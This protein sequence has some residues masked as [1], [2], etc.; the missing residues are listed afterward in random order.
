MNDLDR[1]CGAAFADSTRFAEALGMKKILAAHEQEI[2]A[3]TDVKVTSPEPVAGPEPEPTMSPSTIW[4]LDPVWHRLMITNEEA[5]RQNRKSLQCKEF[6]RSDLGNGQRFALRFGRDARYCH[7]FKSWFIWDGRRW[8]RDKSGLIYELGKDVALRLGDEAPLYEFDT[9][10]QAAFKW[11]AGSQSKSA[12]EN[13]VALARSSLPISPDELDRDPHLFSTMNGTLNI[14]TMEFRE[15]QQR[16]L[17]TKL[18]GVEFYP[19]ASCPQWVDHLNLVFS[20]DAEFISGFQ[21]MC[22]YS[23]IYG[24]PEQLM[25]ILYGTGKNGKSVTLETLA[26]VWGEYAVNVAPESLMKHKNND[27]PRGDIARIAGARLV[28][29]SEGEDGARLAE[30]I[31]KMITG[32]DRVTVRRLYEEEFEFVPAGKVWLSTNHKP[33]IFGTDLAIW[34]RLWLV[35]FNV[36]IPAERRDTHILE[37]L[38]HEGP[39]I[40]NWCLVG[41]KRYLA[42]GKLPQPTRIMEASATYRDESDLLGEFVADRCVMQGEIERR[43]LLAEY[44]N[45]CNDVNEKAVSSKR[46]ATLLR[47]RGV[48]ERKDHGTRTWVGISLAG[49]VKFS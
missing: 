35:P 42:N 18:A 5:A 30:S 34:R 48:S 31:I 10:R 4:Q 41:L 14:Q 33:V 32:G 8:A 7:M 39:G 38:A 2:A 29:S 9:E 43:S 25:F 46:F 12:I 3:A 16:D 44:K 47:D 1:E 28:T 24:N 26:H 45:W 15:H 17:I 23:L 21:E 37:K 49:Q 40:L 27:Q 13:L 19:D 22:G 6:P 36:T 11:A 20:G